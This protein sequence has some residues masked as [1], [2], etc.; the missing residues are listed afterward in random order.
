M[1]SGIRNVHNRDDFTAWL[2]KMIHNS[3]EVYM[4]L[5][6]TPVTQRTFI[7]EHEVLDIKEIVRKI[8]D[9]ID[10]L[11]EKRDEIDLAQLKM[12]FIFHELHSSG[13]SSFGQK[14]ANLME[15]LDAFRGM[16]T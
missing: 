11:H 15:L 6:L 14:R 2:E 13:Q 10:F 3:A 16:M 5:E 12:D 4:L 8:A 1:D 9:K 7:H